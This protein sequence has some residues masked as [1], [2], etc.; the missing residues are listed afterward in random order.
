MFSSGSFNPRLVVSVEGKDKLTRNLPALERLE[1]TANALQNTT[2]QRGTNLVIFDADLHPETRRNTLARVAEQTGTYFSIFLLP[3]DQDSGALENLLLE[4]VPMENQPI[5][6]CFDRFKDCLLGY[7]RPDQP[8]YLPVNKAKVYSYLDALLPSAED[9]H[10]HEARRDYRNPARWNLDTEYLAPLRAF[11]TRHLF[12]TCSGSAGSSATTAYPRFSAS[13]TSHASEASRSLRTWPSRM[14][15]STRLFS[16]PTAR[17]GF[18]PKTCI[19][20]S[21]VRAGWKL[22]RWS[23]SST[24]RSLCS[25]SSKLRR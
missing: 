8:I 21:P 22:R 13:G 18:R 16:S 7:A 5:L 14:A 6:D 23:F 11:L 1:R 24:S 3:N 12:A 17:E 19:I 2:D 15:S 10:R 20:S 25:T 4:C 9:G